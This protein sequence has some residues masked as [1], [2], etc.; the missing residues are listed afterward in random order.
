MTSV[1]DVQSAFSLTPLI[2][3][4]GCIVCLFVASL[5]GFYHF[6]VFRT[7]GAPYTISE[8]SIFSL[9]TGS[10]VSGSFFLGCGNIND[11]TYY[12]YYSLSPNGG[13]ALKRIETDRSTIFM[14]VIGTQSPYIKEVGMQSISCSDSMTDTECISKYSYQF[15]SVYEVHVPLGTIVQKYNGMVNP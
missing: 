8:T 3:F 1:E 6:P 5:F 14:D 7:I 2:L 12:Y 4:V 9:E 11:N 15:N 10:A 13:Y